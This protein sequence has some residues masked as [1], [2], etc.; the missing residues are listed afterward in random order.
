MRYVEIGSVGEKIPVIGLGTYHLLDR[1]VED[2]VPGILQQAQA[3]GINFLDT[4][5]NYG[6]EQ[7]LRAAIMDA[8][9]PEDFFIASKTGLA[10]TYEEYVALQG[11]GRIADLSP[12]R[13]RTNFENSCAMLGAKVI[14]LLQVHAY[15]IATSAEVVV[16]TM[17][18]LLERNSIRYYG[19]SNYSREQFE[20][21]LGVCDRLGLARP[22]TI[23]PQYSL[24]GAHMIDQ[25][26]ELAKEEG[27]TVL[28]HSPLMK[29]VLT[30]GFLDTFDGILKKNR[31]A[32]VPDERVQDFQRANDEIK[33]LHEYAKRRGYSLSEYALAW[34]INQPRVVALTACITPEYVD[35]AVRATEWE[36]DDEGIELAEE[37]RN[38]PQVRACTCTSIMAD[39][40]SQLRPYYARRTS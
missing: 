30:D 40:A 4:S 6:Y 21:L 29:G 26:I 9:K 22:A 19:V 10:L 31:D 32:G 2:Q 5:D 35:S 13:V 27:I 3:V 38:N 39:V 25:G 16:H 1:V 20:E 8:E 17:N 28:A 18:S 11:Q 23:Q 33:R 37:V 34:L 24:L 36:L 12:E 7:V 14:D 15:D